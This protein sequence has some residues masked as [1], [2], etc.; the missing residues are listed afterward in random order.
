M[1]LCFDKRGDYREIN[2]HSDEQNTSEKNRDFCGLLERRFFN[3][4]FGEK[5]F[6][7]LPEFFVNSSKR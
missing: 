3:V 2:N 5:G 1:F 4:A 7:F 6:D